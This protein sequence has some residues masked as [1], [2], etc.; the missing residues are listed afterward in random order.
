MAQITQREVNHLY[1]TLKITRTRGV[2]LLTVFPGLLLRSAVLGA[3][4]LLVLC[5]GK[6]LTL[7]PPNR[8]VLGTQPG[9]ALWWAEARLCL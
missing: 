4:S 7:L 1:L 9:A 2:Y 5:S 3:S 8:R 6:S